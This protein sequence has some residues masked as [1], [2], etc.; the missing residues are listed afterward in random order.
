MEPDAASRPLPPSPDVLPATATPDALAAVAAARRV[1]RA[2]RVSVVDDSVRAEAAALL[3]Q[4]AA[5]LEADVHPGPHCQVGFAP[6][7]FGE[8]SS[9]AQYFPYSPI[10]GPM[11]PL[12]PPVD[13]QVQPDRTVSGSVTLHEGY[14]GPPW[15]LAHGG[16]IAAIFDELLG[17]ASIAAAG[18]GFTGSLTIHFR[19]PTPVLKPIA[20][21]GWLDRQEGRKLYMR[22]EMVAEGVM[23]A[24]A[25]GVFI[26]TVGPLN[27]EPGA[28]T[29]APRGGG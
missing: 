5:L 16:V 28:P 21:R 24:E 6:P 29:T 22:G 20:L 13:F 8:G 4:A 18:G 1:N 27:D 11:N 15:N 17:V 25:E 23:T 19:K 9:P 12:S 7:D 14:N 10:V 3:D 26:L 2:L